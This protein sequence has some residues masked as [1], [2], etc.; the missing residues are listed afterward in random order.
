MTDNATGNEIDSAI[1]DRLALALDVDDL[2][3]AIRL[4]RTFKDYFGVAKIGLELY[5][6]AGPE[7][8]GAISDLGY[9]IFLD[10]KLH[11]IPTTVGKA[12]RVSVRSGCS[13]SPCTLTV[14]S[15]CCGP[16]SRDSRK[17]LQRRPGA[18][19]VARHHGAH[20]RRRCSTSHHAEAG[21]ARCRGGML[22][23]RVRRWRPRRG[24][25]YA[26]ASPE[27][28]RAFG[29]RATTPTT[30]RAASPGDALAGG[31]DLLVVGRAVT[32]PTTRSQPRRRSASA[33]SAG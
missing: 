24:T 31:S 9:K 32:A 23:H 11:D 22:G 27:S 15:T 12:A 8:I 18:T 1:R 17:A 29:S 25:P 7:A 21:H 2:V 16:V 4:G 28:R 20:E 3:A 19:P 13:T 10:L 5:S 26:P 6:A 30:R 14:G 33:A